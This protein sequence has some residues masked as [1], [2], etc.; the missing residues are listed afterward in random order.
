MNLRTSSTYDEKAGTKGGYSE[1][2]GYKMI[3]VCESRDCFEDAVADDG[4]C[5]EHTNR[6]CS[7]AIC[8][9]NIY[10]N[11]L[12]KEHYYQ[13]PLKRFH[14]AKGSAKVRRI[15][16]TLTKEDYINLISK[17]C[18]YCDNRNGNVQDSAGIGLD[19]IN[20]SFGYTQDNVLPCCWQCNVTRNNLYTV[21]E[22]KVMISAM[23][24]CRKAAMKKR[25]AE[26]VDSESVDFADTELVDSE[27]VDF[28]DTE[29]VDVADTEQSLTRLIGD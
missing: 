26:L 7:N 23:L 8:Y 20:H 1:K 5:K 4:F 11:R 17:P 21:E 15:Q 14:N 24:E 6:L 2:S 9:D 28:A 27:S 16:F 13:S 29:L 19:R 18:E 22:T 3:N 12:C 10:K 25:I